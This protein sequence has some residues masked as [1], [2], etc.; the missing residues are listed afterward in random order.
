MEENNRLKLLIIGL[1]LAAI[2]V[3]YFILAQ[4]FEGDKIQ[5]QQATNEQSGIMTAQDQGTTPTRNPSVLGQN[6]NQ[7]TLDRMEQ[8][9]KAGNSGTSGNVQT[10]PNTGLPSALAA[11]FATSAIISGWFLRRFPQ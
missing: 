7:T 5:T 2:V 3:G 6:S 9:Q 1:V 8:S 4:R 11:V 10:L